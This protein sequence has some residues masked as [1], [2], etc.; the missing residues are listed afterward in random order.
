MA[1]PIDRRDVDRLVVEHLPA[2]LGLA[3]RLSGEA[4][5]AEEIVQEALCRVLRRWRSFRG[6]AS[7]KTWML[8]IVVNVDRDRRR[9]PVVYNPEPNASEEPLATT[10]SPPDQASARELHA[11]LRAAV[12]RLP[13]RQREVALLTLGEG[14][15]AGEVAAIL[16]ISESNVYANIHLARKQVARAIGLD[17]VSQKPS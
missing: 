7:F 8:Q 11:E 5:A 10:A 4:D 16:A 3:R 17:I 1:R 2:A 15:A 9:R 13:R 6:E 12:D 14:L